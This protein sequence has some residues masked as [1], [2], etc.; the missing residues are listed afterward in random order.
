MHFALA[1]F[2]ILHLLTGPILIVQAV[3]FS[4]VFV[5]PQSIKVAGLLILAFG[6]LEIWRNREKIRIELTGL[7]SLAAVFAFLLT[8]F[9]SLAMWSAPAV[10][11]GNTLL[12]F[13]YN[14]S[15]LPLF[16]F[17]AVIDFDFHMSRW[18][19][20]AE[21]ALYFF[22]LPACLVAFASFRTGDF[23]LSRPVEMLLTEGD[24]IKFDYIGGF[25]RGTAW[26]R[27]PVDLG[28]FACIILAISGSRILFRGVSVLEIGK[29]LIALVG[30]LSTVSRTIAVM[31]A[32]ILGVLGCVKIYKM[33]GSSA[34]SRSILRNASAVLA[35]ILAG[36]IGVQGYLLT[37]QWMS[38]ATDTT[39]LQ[40]RFRNWWDLL[41]QVFDSGTTAMFGLGKIQNGRYGPWHT[42][43]VDNTYI[44]ILLTGGLV[45]FFAFFAAVFFTARMI[46]QDLRRNEQLRIGQPVKFGESDAVAYACIA[47]L[48]AMGLASMAENNMRIAYY[49][50]AVLILFRAAVRSNSRTS[51]TQE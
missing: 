23:F 29:L 19:R 16:F 37:S 8:S 12:A 47:Y 42:L 27:S 30:I 9:T 46:R 32:A 18:V 21:T 45:S 31:A 6:F 43:E 36:A 40:N 22:T 7:L 26:F 17:I 35:L 5:T 50:A 15:F 44:G 39:N 51:S 48:L 2:L 4:R 3:I 25:V 10:G 14:Y 33:A 49:A 41:L 1:A 13:A 11:W 24:F 28:M 34:I 38:V 20:F